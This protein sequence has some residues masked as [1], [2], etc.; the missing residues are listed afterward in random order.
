MAL[1][2]FL[3]LWVSTCDS[4][5]LKDVPLL[6]RGCWASWFIWGLRWFRGKL[7]FSPCEGCLPL[8]PCVYLVG[9]AWRT[10]V[11]SQ[12]ILFTKAELYVSPTPPTPTLPTPW[13]CKKLCSTFQ[14]LS[15]LLELASAQEEKCPPNSKLP[16]SSGY[17]KAHCS[18]SAPC[19][20]RGFLCS[21]DFLKI[22][23]LVGVEPQL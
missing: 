1:C 7:G 15:L 20:S 2:V 3:H 8:V 4:F 9:F 6:L 22:T 16:S 13:I 21:H 17:I 5:F 11:A 23:E 18:G 12:S 14:Q 10:W 19:S